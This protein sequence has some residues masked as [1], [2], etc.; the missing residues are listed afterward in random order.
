MI[1]F[2]TSKEL[3]HYLVSNHNAKLLSIDEGFEQLEDNTLATSGSCSLDEIEFHEFDWR[4]NNGQ[5][6]VFKI[7]FVYDA[8]K[9]A[10]TYY[11]KE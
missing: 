7:A 11:F 2:D 4:D 10:D 1:K 5:N 9:D 8:E 3:I 6:V